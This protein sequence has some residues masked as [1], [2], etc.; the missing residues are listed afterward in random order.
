MRYILLV[1]LNSPIVLLALANIFV[2]FKMRKMD[3]ARFVRQVILWLLI[4]LIIIGS[5]PVYNVAI[6]KPLFDSSNLSLIDVVQATAITYLFYIVNNQRRNAEQTE[7]TLRD[8][9]QEVS[10]EL[11]NRERSHGKR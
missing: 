6:G 2:Q 7:R 4:F 5:F 8:L 3:R 10:I 1:I 11:A 9:H